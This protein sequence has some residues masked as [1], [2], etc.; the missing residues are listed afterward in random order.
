MLGVPLLREGEW[1]GRSFSPDSGCEPFTERQIELVRT[2]ADQAVIA[3]ENT[4]LITETREA[5]EQ[6]TATA[7]ILEVINRSP[8]DLAP[9]YD[10]ILEKARSL[11]GVPVGGLMLYDGE[12][13]RTVSLHGFPE[14]FIEEASRPFPPGPPLE[15]L[16]RGERLLHEPDY[17]AVALRPGLHPAARALVEMGVRTTLV[18]PLRKDGKLLGCIA[19]NRL[20]VRPFSDKEIALLES[21]AA[22][23]VIAMDNARLLDEIRQRQA[24]LRVTFDNMGD[25]VAMFDSDLRLA[26]WNLQFPADPRTPRSFA[27]RAAA[28]RRLCP[29]PRRARRIRRGR[30]RSGG[31]PAVGTRRTTM[32]GRADA[33]GWPGHRGAQQPGA[34]RRGCADL[35]RHHRA[36]A[37]RGRDPRGARHRRSAPCRNCRRRKPA[38]CTPRRWRH[39]VS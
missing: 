32:V 14:Q 8:G 20:E 16:I 3:I 26:A 10:V 2:F 30:C 37:R 4:R 27:R 22:Q 21:F 15:R 23:A 17:R 1:S 35:Q 5:L 13:V 12:H 11:C 31:A 19:A 29:L 28:R 25:G 7:E 9:V 36:Q 39:S 38:C 33:A 6:Q 34:G 24:E 18:V